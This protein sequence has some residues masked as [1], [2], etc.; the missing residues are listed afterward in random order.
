MDNLNYVSNVPL[1]DNQNQTN[2]TPPPPPTEI[3]QSIHEEVNPGSA[4]SRWASS[5]LDSIYLGLG[6]IP[7]FIIF[8]LLLNGKL[9]IEKEVINQLENNTVLQIFG[10]IALFTYVVGF[11]VKKGATLGKAG[12]HLK[13][14]KYGTMEY[15]SYGRAFARE[16]LKIISYIPVI[17][18]VYFIINAIMIMFTK[19]K[20]PIYDLI[21]GTQ[22]VKMK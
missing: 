6:A 5:L 4:Y 18:T 19:Q 12:Y 17:G 14:V 10:I 15:M 9:S 16:L 20:R 22:V 8:E 1:S 11:N 3:S 7:V 21:A 2:I 13:I